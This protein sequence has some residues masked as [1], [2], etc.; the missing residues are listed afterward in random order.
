MAHQQIRLTRPMAGRHVVVN[1]VLFVVGNLDVSRRSAVPRWPPS[2]SLNSGRSR[3]QICAQVTAGGT[4]GKMDASVTWV[5][6]GQQHRRFRQEPP[7]QA[8]P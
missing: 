5:E 1:H 7:A 4:N 6:N 3:M 8:Q 2:A